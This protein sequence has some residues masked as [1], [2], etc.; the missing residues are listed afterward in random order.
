MSE[1]PVDLTI[2]SAMQ[3]AGVSTTPDVTYLFTESFFSKNRGL[4]QLTTNS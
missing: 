1:V 3:A 4:K 2:S